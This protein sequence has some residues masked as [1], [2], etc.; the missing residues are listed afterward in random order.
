[1]LDEFLKLLEKQSVR[2]EP[3]LSLDFD[4]SSHGNQFLLLDGLS[5]LMVFVL[6]ESVVN[7]DENLLSSWEL[8]RAS[9]EGLEDVLYF[10][11]LDSDRDQFVTD[12][13]PGGLSIGLTEG[14]PH[15]GLESI[16][17]CAGQ[18]FVDPE[19]VPRVGPHSE[20]EIVLG[21]LSYQVLVDGD[22]AGLEGLRGDL[23]LF[24]GDEMDAVG[25]GAPV[26]LLGSSVEE[27][28]FGVGAGS[29]VPALGVGLSLD[30]S[31]A[32]E[33]SSTHGL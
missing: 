19:H 18:H 23:L 4:M 6:G 13:D 11:L 28:Q 32:S 30:V 22:S 14:L 2:Q 10:V 12:P 8:V 27:S 26:G 3:F 1:M 31:V 16:R 17:S 5:Y 15:S 25:E 24:V 29:V 33:W 21:H 7:R 20:V 9:S